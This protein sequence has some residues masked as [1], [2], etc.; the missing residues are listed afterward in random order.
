[1]PSHNLQFSVNKSS[2]DFLRG[3][4][5][6]DGGEHRSLLGLWLGRKRKQI[7]I[8]RW[9]AGEMGFKDRPA[10]QRFPRSL[11]TGVETL[12]QGPLGFLSQG[13]LNDTKTL[14]TPSDSL[15]TPVIHRAAW[16]QQCRLWNLIFTLCI[17]WWVLWMD[18]KLNVESFSTFLESLHFWRWFHD[19]QDDSSH[20]E[21][22]RAQISTQTSLMTGTIRLTQ[23]AL[24]KRTLFALI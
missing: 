14:S 18:V 23:I 9:G 1:M 15:S 19:S 16:W 20:S 24:H 7:K 22:F 11:W 6:M 5:D 2:S 21:L 12:L 13:P 4:F 10:A 8:K 17:R 3:G